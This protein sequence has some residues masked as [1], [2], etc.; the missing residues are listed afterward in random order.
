MGYAKNHQP[1]GHWRNV[2]QAPD[3]P[4]DIE[5]ASCDAPTQVPRRGELGFCDTCLDRSRHSNRNIYDELGG[6]D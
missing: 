2:R 4:A 5:C 6:G 1:H 3:Q